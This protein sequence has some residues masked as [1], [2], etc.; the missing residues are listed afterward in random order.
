MAAR[1]SASDFQSVRRS[2]VNE[3]EQVGSGFF[4]LRS[5]GAELKQFRPEFVLLLFQL[6]Q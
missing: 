5:V 4:L 2:L 1:E 3:I 6:G